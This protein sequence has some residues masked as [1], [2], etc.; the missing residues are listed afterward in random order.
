MTPIESNTAP[1]TTATR[2]LDAIIIDDE[3]KA[4]AVLRRLIDR[5]CPQVKVLAE[6]EDVEDGVT[7]IRTMRPQLVFLDVDLSGATGFDLLERLEDRRFHVILVT[8]HP[9]YAVKAFRYSVT[10]YLLKPVDDEELRRAVAKVAELVERDAKQRPDADRPLRHTLR[11]PSTEGAVFVRMEDIMRLEAEGAYT[12][13]HVAGKRHFSSYNLKQFEEH[14]DPAWFM[15]V[16]RS[17]VV[18]LRMVRSVQDR[19]G[20]KLELVDGTQV[21]VSRRQKADLLNLIG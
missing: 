21:P 16:H 2:S 7:A 3:A 1:G 15:R 9:E 17:H 13:I 11:I 10:D 12:H 8:A 14:L 6:A 19:D 20:L 18:N 5:A 4:I